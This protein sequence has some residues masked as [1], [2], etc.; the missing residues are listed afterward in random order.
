MGSE[1][2]IRDRY[3]QGYTKTLP[4]DLHIDLGNHCNLACKMC[5][6]KASSTIASQ[7][8]RW[9]IETSRQYLGTDWTKDQAVWERFLHQLLEIPQLK[10][11][12]FMGGETLLSRRLEQLVDFFIK[13]ERYEV[14][15]SFVTNGTIYPHALM[16]KM[17]RFARLGIEISIE[18]MTKH[19]EYQRQGT[20]HDHVMRNIQSF[21][22]W[23]NGKN[24]TVTLRTAPSILSVGRYYTL[25]DYAVRNQ[26]VIKSNFCYSPSF[27]R[28][29]LLPEDIKRLYLDRLNAW[30]ASVDWPEGSD[31]D[32]NASDP[33]NVLL[34]VQNQLDMIRSCLTRPQ[35]AD[36][37]NHLRQLVE[38]CKRWDE[39]YNLN[40]RELYP[41][42]GLIL[43]RY[44]YDL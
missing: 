17:S 1:M 12:H 29:E 37:E 30:A 40:A 11:I 31:R 15:F 21:R 43:D 16:T 25:L 6:A 39:I 24:I 5:D 36:S 38:H 33:H 22:Q 42:F 44:E 7:Q 2:C 20:D 32:F 28:A 35:P 3:N 27:M 9:G 8:V 13:H 34:I 41:E 14:C 10:N 19:N 26:M 23:D 4:I 18:T